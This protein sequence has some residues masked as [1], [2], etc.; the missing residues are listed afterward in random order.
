MNDFLTPAEMERRAA[1]AGMSIKDLAAAA[2]ISHTT[3]YRWRAGKSEP[4]LDVYKRLY[5]ALPC[6]AA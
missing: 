6:E 1:L 4:S 2:G 3:F 5:R